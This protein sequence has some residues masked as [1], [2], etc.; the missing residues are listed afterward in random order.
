MPRASNIAKTSKSEQFTVTRVML[1]AV[2][3]DQSFELTM[4]WCYRWNHRTLK[5]KQKQKTKNK[6]KKWWSLKVLIDLVSR[7]SET[8]KMQNSLFSSVKANNG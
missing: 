1:I 5:T 2:V 3:R 6:N 7:D 4:A 8:L